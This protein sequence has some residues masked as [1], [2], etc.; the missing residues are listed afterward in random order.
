V[1]GISLVI[2]TV[3]DVAVR[4][5]VIHI[6]L[7]SME[8]AYYYGKCWHFFNSTCVDAPPPYTG[9]RGYFFIKTTDLLWVVYIL[10]MVLQASTCCRLS[11]TSSIRTRY[12]GYFVL[13]AIS[14]FRSCSFIF[15]ILNDAVTHCPRN[16]RSTGRQK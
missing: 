13:M 3:A 10:E 9:F 8:C 6:F 4:F 5:P 14:A 2:A 7:S 12:I 11:V 15:T 1:I 16:Y